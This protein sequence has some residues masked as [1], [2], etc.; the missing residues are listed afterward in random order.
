MPKME[1]LFTGPRCR[2]QKIH[3]SHEWKKWCLHL[4]CQCGSGKEEEG[5]KEFLERSAHTW[6]KKK[7]I[8]CFST[9]AQ[10]RKVTF[11]PWGKDGEIWVREVFR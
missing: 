7:L 4:L 2:L 11:I 5:M 10:E 3:I 6:V 8:S 1:N 9:A